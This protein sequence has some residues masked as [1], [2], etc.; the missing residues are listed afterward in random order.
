VIRWF[1]VEGFRGLVGR[2]CLADCQSAIQQTNCLRYAGGG[3]QIL[4][5]LGGVFW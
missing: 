2:R 4:A 1:W 3:A 5:S